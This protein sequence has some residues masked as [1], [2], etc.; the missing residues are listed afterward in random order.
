MIWHDNLSGTLG[1]TPVMAKPTLSPKKNVLSLKMYQISFVRTT[2]F[3]S[4]ASPKWLW[5][6]V[7]VS[8]KS[9][10]IGKTE[11]VNRWVVTLFQSKKSLR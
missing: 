3:A 4:T 5:E 1:T 8:F 7:G 6:K 11:T 10:P 2:I 9:E